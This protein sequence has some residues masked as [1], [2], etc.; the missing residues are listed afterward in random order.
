LFGVTGSG[1]TQVYLEAI[2]ATLARGRTALV[3][4]PEIALTPFL[5][6][7]FRAAFANRVAIQHSAQSP[8]VRYD[9]WR[10]I[11]AGKYPVVIGARSAIFAPLEN[12]GLIVVDEEQEPS[13]KQSESPPLYHARDCALVRARLEGAAIVLGSATP[14]METFH[15]AQSGRYE[16]LEL[17]ERVGGALAPEVE[18]VNWRPPTPDAD[19][20]NETYRRK[21]RGEPR[22]PLPEPPIITP[23]LRDRLSEVL[24]AG[25]QAILL[26]N[27]RGHSPFLIC[28]T[29][30]YIPQCPNCSVSQTYHRKG[31]AL[32]CHYCDHRDP[33]AVRCPQCGS[34]EWV[35][36][37]IGTQRLE[38]ELATLFPQARILRM[39]SDTAAGYGRHSKMVTAFAQHEYDLLVGTQMIAKGLDFSHVDL[40]AVVRADAELF[41]PDFRAS[42]RGASLIIQLA[43][44]AGRRERRG[45][46]IIQSSVPEH[47]VLQAVV[48][49]DWRVFAEGE[50]EQR[51]R[52]SFPPFAR[53]VLLRA[54]ARDESLAVRALLKLR[55]LLQEEKM[56]DV[57]GPAPAIIVKVENLFRYSLLVRTRRETDNSGA[58]LRG[59]VK[60]AVAA[61]REQKGEPGVKLELDVDPQSSY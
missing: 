9:L 4:L 57:L 58:T 11:R 33:A 28:K 49:G 41:F 51:E 7:R 10:E 5:W 15:L 48:H 32:R 39:D 2:R 3:L 40:A 24:D 52:S 8:G 50:L 44:R 47:P 30:G 27:R 59:A 18:I 14:S 55:R 34:E 29:C 23:E 20:R 56:V 31:A 17:P 19:E 35:R 61:F 22:E 1:K 38:D 12:I 21:A 60:R 13:F 53:L 36:C 37:G 42:E 26:Q 54:I 43:G 25:R 6:S 45:H 46:V 16:L